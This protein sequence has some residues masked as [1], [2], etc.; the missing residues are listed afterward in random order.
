MIR[1]LRLELRR[2]PAWLL[3][4]VLAG[5][6]WIA[7]PYGR[8]L[9]APVVLWSARSDAVQG[10]LQ[11]VG[12]FAAGI[13]AWMA[14][15][16]PRN[17]MTDLAATT[18][19][20]VLERRMVTC[21]ATTLC[22]LVLY[23]VA[24]AI[25]YALTAGQVTWGTPAWGPVAAGALGVV[26]FSAS[27]F[28]LGTFLPGRFIAP[29]TAIVLLLGLQASL[30]DQGAALA[31]LSPVAN[32]V[33]QVVTEF[34]G[35]DN[36]VAILQV[37]F[38]AGVTVA[39]L[40]ALARGP[41]RIAAVAV[42]LAVAG[43]AVGLAGTSH[44]DPM[45]RVVVAGLGP[46]R[47]TPLPFTPVCDHGGPLPVCTHPV[48]QSLLAQLDGD[49]GAVTSQVAGL[50]GAPDTVRIAMP[51]PSPPTA[52]NLASV[53]LTAPVSAARLRTVVRV[54]AARTLTGAGVR[55][56]NSR[57]P[58][59]DAQLA[60]ADGMLLVAGERAPGP[61]AASA[62]GAASIRFAALTPTARR[63]WLGAHLADLR[64]GTVDLK[65]LP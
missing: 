23:L 37:L 3:L 6:I 4:P 24:A 35:M 19:R 10:S 62:V 43:A 38:L 13:A 46:G 9:R 40:A 45:G 48:F 44:L 18:S 14:G 65:E 56:Q 5:L 11:V 1:L 61:G 7:S 42:G 59:T 52:L 26:A 20:P 25:M 55:A 41:G 12:P 50:P 39:T 22:V 2:T 49:L 16:D 17:R 34:Y 36:S 28:A 31:S 57:G 58:G 29:L 53:Y 30:A 15:R 27:G 60:V 54:A 64:A 33:P 32:G 51:P 63:A 21:A 47:A 8:V